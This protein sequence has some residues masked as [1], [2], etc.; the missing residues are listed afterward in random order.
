MFGEI[1]KRL[2]CQSAGTSIKENNLPDKKIHLSL[3]VMPEEE[4]SRRNT[5]IKFPNGWKPC[6]PKKGWQSCQT[7]PVFQTFKMNGKTCSVYPNCKE[8]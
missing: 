6:L 8:R 7:P 5:W 3:E 1:E 4:P 2:I